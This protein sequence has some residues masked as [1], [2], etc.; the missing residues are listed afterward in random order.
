MRP[1]LSPRM[2]SRWHQEYDVLAALII[3]E[4]KTRFGHLRLGLLWAFLEPLAHVAIFSLAWGLRGH[5][6]VMG[7]HSYYFILSG[8]LPWNL[9]QNIVNRL[10]SAPEANA[11][12]FSFYQVRP[13]HA[14]AARGILEGALFL[15]IF[16]LNV[17]IGLYLD[18][19]FSVHDL[20]TVAVAY[21]TLFALAF[22]VG[23]CLAIL[24][25]ELPETEKFISVFIRILYFFSGVF[26][27]CAT[28]PYS[29]QVF[30]AWNPIL[31]LIDTGRAGLFDLE[32]STFENLDNTLLITAALLLLFFALYK[33]FWQRMM[34]T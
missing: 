32:V 28:L 14:F 22:A 16:L 6:M 1:S 4:T 9:F 31:V 7:I 11:G 15:L 12:L 24:V 2:R 23:G 26:F 18:L 8:I 13:L 29:N 33:K 30:F 20:L 19:P 34:A 17:A 25:S 5:Y 21:L 3:R 27:S 10:I